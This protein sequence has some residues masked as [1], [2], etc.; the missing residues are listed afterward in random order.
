MDHHLKFCKILKIINIK[1]S[2]LK[3][4][5]TLEKNFIL[6][7]MLDWKWWKKLSIFFKHKSNFFL[8]NRQT[9][10]KSTKKRK[11]HTIWIKS[12]FGILVDNSYILLLFFLYSIKMVIGN[13]AFSSEQKHSILTDFCWISI[14]KDS[15]F[16]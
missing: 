5:K 6:T 8:L 3:N 2:Q 12:A 10:L 4:N 11:N 1:N 15:M 9:N 16:K 7:T 14:L 13:C